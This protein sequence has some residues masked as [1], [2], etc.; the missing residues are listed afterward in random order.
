MRMSIR[1]TIPAYHVLSTLFS[2]H[3]IGMTPAEMHGLISGMI[4]GGNSDQSWLILVQDFTNEGEAFHYTLAQPVQH[5]HQCISDTLENEGLLFQLCLPDD[6]DSVFGRADAL[7]GWVSHFLSGLGLMQPRMDKVSG[8]TGEAIDDLHTIS[9]LGYDEDEDQEALKQS[10][11]EVIEYVRLA[12]L[13]C[14]DTFARQLPAAT[15]EEIKKNT[16]H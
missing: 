12:A 6:S 5:M 13:L 16:L 11:A 10:L 3:K 9:L 1:N 4:C 7:A 8:E 2:Q 15:R 14:H